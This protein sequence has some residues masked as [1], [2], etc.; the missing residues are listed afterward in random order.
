V[1]RGFVLAVHRAP[2]KPLPRRILRLQVCRG[3]ANRAA[4]PAATA[5]L[6]DSASAS[7]RA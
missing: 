1:K 3:A 2:I 5:P 4:S 6:A 7:E